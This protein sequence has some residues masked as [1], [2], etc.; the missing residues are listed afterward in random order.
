[1]KIPKRLEPLVEDGLIDAVIRPLMSGKEAS[2]YVVREGKA[3]RTP[4]ELGY[5]DGNFVEVRKGLEPG[6]AVVTAG[7]V[8]LRDGGLVQVFGPRMAAAAADA[9]NDSSGER[10]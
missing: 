3:V 10:Q 9:S 5:I 7:K 1:M 2:V 8:A 4:I 6:D